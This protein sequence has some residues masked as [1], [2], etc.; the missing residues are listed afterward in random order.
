M[1]PVM[2]HPQPGYTLLSLGKRDL[3]LAIATISGGDHSH[4]SLWTGEEVIEST[5]PEVH[6]IP[7]GGLA[8]KS[9]HVDALRHGQLAGRE[10]ALIAHAQSYL[11][12]H[13]CTSLLAVASAIGTLTAWL[14]QHNDWL[15]HNTQY[16]TERALA[17]LGPLARWLEVA[18][19]DR[20]TCVELV[21]NAHL[22][23]GLP[24]SVRLHPGGKL[25]PAVLLAGIKDMIVLAH[26]QPRV[27][28]EALTALGSAEASL[29]REIAWM[30]GVAEAIQ[31]ASP[32]ADADPSAQER[33]VQELKALILPVS[34]RWDDAA[35]FSG[36]VTPYQLATSPSFEP[37][38]RVQPDGTIATRALSRE[39][40][41]GT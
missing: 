16:T 22:R 8:E 35:W 10:A 40:R 2:A 30:S 33:S 38:G 23:A 11:G 28:R 12:Q 19:S 26:S 36:L 3:G 27:A 18:T 4:V 15:A 24:I 29:E 37:V 14:H 7:L 1:P 32:P 17:L 25:D 31:A 13:Y 9:L 39:E 41:L 6:A 21:V 5:F 20:V 34:E